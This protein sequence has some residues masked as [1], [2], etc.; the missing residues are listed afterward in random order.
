ML[1]GYA[2]AAQAL[3][4]ICWP[5]VGHYPNNAGK[6][7]STSYPLHKKFSGLRRCAARGVVIALANL[8]RAELNKLASAERAD[9][10]RPLDVYRC[11]PADHFALIK[12]PS[13][14]ECGRQR[15]GECWSPTTNREREIAP[16]NSDRGVAVMYIST[17]TD[18]RDR[19]PVQ[20]VVQTAVQR[21]MPRELIG[22]ESP[23]LLG[24]G[25][26]DNCGANSAV[27]RV[28]QRLSAINRPGL[29]RFHPLF[30]PFP[31]STVCRGGCSDQRP[32]PLQAEG[33][34]GRA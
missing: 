1:C 4:S 24:G 15:A 20:D 5:K 27:F 11:R 29:A 32:E 7:L 30:A 13:G 10:R 33:S 2:A 31:R 23:D 12:R 21:H 9:P 16:R 8:R 26:E 22:R 19:N 14:G 28:N 3:H 34:H 25:G 17:R 6:T 18:R